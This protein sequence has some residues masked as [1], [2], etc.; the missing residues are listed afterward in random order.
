MWTNDQTPPPSADEREATL[1]DRRR[2]HRIRSQAEPGPRT[3]E[4]AVAQHET[5]APL[6]RR[7]RLLEVEDRRQPR[8]QRHRQVVIEGIGLGLHRP[9]RAGE[10]NSRNA[11]R[12]EAPCPHG[13]AGG[14]EMVRRL[15]TQPGWS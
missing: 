2:H 5:L 14:Q 8:P 6:D 15:G 4:A 13:A 3:V 11:L 10:S 12:H 9:A 7:H 1:A